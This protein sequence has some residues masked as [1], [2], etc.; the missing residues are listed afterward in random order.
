MR[1]ARFVISLGVVGA[2]VVILCWMGLS[3]PPEKPQQLVRQRVSV[4]TAPASRRP[5]P[6]APLVQPIAQVRSA[7]AAK[8][9]PKRAQPSK[10]ARAQAPSPP[11]ASRE[12]LQALEESIAAIEEARPV[13]REARALPSLS[14]PPSLQ[15]PHIPVA[16]SYEE[17]LTRALH[18]A[19][20][21]PEY[22]EVRIR[23]VLD[24]QGTVASIEVLATESEAN[25]KYLEKNLPGLK[26][27]Q[28][29]SASRTF[30]LTFCNEI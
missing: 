6:V 20:Q 24:A 8:P 4:R 26:F 15:E 19:L 27:P 5:E 3:A 7:R 9:P 2:H 12:L 1:R 29:G 25:R 14:S 21:L 13:R 30:V 22:G 11:R 17:E 28:T 23:L 18:R 16:P 10:T